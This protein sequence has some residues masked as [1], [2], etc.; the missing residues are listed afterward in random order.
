MHYTAR[1]AGGKKSG[2]LKM[3]LCLAG[4]LSTVSSFG[5]DYDHWAWS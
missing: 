3:S 5:Y 4:A 1:F 2:Q